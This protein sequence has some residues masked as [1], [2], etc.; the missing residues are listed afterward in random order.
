MDAAEDSDSAARPVRPGIP[1]EVRPA[2][3]LPLP[4]DLAGVRG[5]AVSERAGVDDAEGEDAADEAPEAAGAADRAGDRA[6]FGAEATSHRNA[7]H[8]SPNGCG[9]AVPRNSAIASARAATGCV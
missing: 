2:P 1:S 3:P 4:G 5:A 7:G 8:A 6:A 9:G